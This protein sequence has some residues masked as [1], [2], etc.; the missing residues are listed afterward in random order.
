MSKFEKLVLR[1]LWFLLVAKYGTIHSFNG[2]S[3]ARRDWEY[4][5]GCAARSF[6]EE[7]EKE[8]AE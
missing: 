2:S 3:H 6:S 4:H 5:I 8:A 7:L 1:A